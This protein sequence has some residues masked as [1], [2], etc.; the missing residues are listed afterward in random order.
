MIRIGKHNS[1]DIVVNDRLSEEFH[2]VIYFNEGQLRLIDQNSR[3][4]TLVNG[5]KVRDIEL[6]QGDVI[7]IGF[8]KIDWES[9]CLV[10]ENMVYDGH[11][12]EPPAELEM[13]E[14]IVTEH[15]TTVSTIEQTP[16]F[17]GVI[18]EK[19]LLDAKVT[20][21]SEWN[22]NQLESEL[23]YEARPLP[24]SEDVSAAP[25]L[26]NEED[27]PKVSASNLS[28]QDEFSDTSNQSDISISPT[29][30]KSLLFSPYGLLLL[31]VLG[32]AGL[33]WLAGFLA[34]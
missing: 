11:A 16:I 23:D 7:Q 5:Q 33:G 28:T 26:N 1:N 3:F 15:E 4:G 2:C 9:K 30:N 17:S 13:E 21:I 14:P 6:S 25:A 27:S 19:Y 20:L 32:M 34:H 24:N 22:K 10:S 31:I 29:S 12:S 18:P 8:A